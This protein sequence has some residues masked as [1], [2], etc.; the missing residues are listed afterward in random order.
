MG[1]R[2]DKKKLLCSPFIPKNI[3]STAVEGI[4]AL[5]YGQ[6]GGP[7]FDA[8]TKQIVG[9]NSAIGDGFVKI[10]PLTGFLASMG[11]Q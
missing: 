2:L 9:L 1:F 3:N 10:Y 8:E 11:I 5:F 4:G 7:V 6:S